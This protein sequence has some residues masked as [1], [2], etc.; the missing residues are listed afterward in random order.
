MST[1]DAETLLDLVRPLVVV[2]D[3]TGTVVMARGGAG[4]FLGYDTSALVGLNVLDV[5]PADEQLD[6]ATYFVAL[7]SEPVNSTRL[8]IP[9]RSSVIGADGRVHTVDVIPTAL[10]EHLGRSGWA[11]VLVPLS[12]EAGASRSLDAELGGAPRHLVKQLLTE[13]L[14]LSNGEWLTRWFLVDLPEHDE[15]A[16]VGS[17][18]G[19]AGLAEPIREAFLSGWLP[20]PGA[21]DTAERMF[22]VADLPEPLRSAALD[23]GWDIVGASPVVCDGRLVAALLR[24]GRSL[25]GDRTVAVRTNV[26]SRIRG[27]LEVTTLL[28]GRWRERDRLIAAAST[29]PLT[30]LANRDAFHD[31]LADAAGAPGASVIY[32]DV[33][34]FKAVND[35]WGHDV[36]DRVLVE[37]AR[38]IVHAC[39][40]ADL[41]A[42]M[43]GDEFVVLLRDV[44]ASV[45]REVG[46]R[47]LD[48]V[49]RPLG[50][51]HGPGA[52]SVSVGLA[53]AGDADV[54]ALADRAMLTAK[55]QGRARLVSA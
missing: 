9:F 34:R 26:V 41:V 48:E 8:P 45:A 17:R 20:W 2:V 35:E 42:R 29:D 47:I 4:G 23:G 28:Y 55:R 32:V 37:V 33:D 39:R 52:V 12:L 38:R 7:A 14:E 21:A 43:G 22:E 49:G 10:P 31:A 46:E 44:D 6:V 11:V 18:S 25:D 15:P 19:D 13:E 3:G 24:V 51:E 53:V 40:A 30:G 16:V 27:L 54:V 5:V 36:G 1:I 50:L